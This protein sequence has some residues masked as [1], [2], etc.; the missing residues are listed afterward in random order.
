ME[1]AADSAA[2]KG[3]RRSCA[4]QTT[5]AAG[6]VKNAARGQTRKPNVSPGGVRSFFERPPVDS[7]FPYRTRARPPARPT[8]RRPR[9]RPTPPGSRRRRRRHRRR[10]IAA[11]ASRVKTIRVPSSPRACVRPSVRP[12]VHPCAV[13]HTRPHCRRRFA[14]SPVSSLL[15][16]RILFFTR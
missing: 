12:S 2:V 5:A 14:R 4:A 7:R 9:P 6:G 8:D 1:A 16:I 15:L 10:R 13:S 3:Q 11:A